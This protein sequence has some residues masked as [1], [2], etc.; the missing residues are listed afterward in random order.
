M[1]SDSSTVGIVVGQTVY[2]RNG[3]EVGTI[4]ATKT[5][6]GGR[7]RAV[8]G[9]RRFLGLSTKNV[10]IP[11]SKL[12]AREAGGFAATLTVAEIRKLPET[13]ISPR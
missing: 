1:S 7:Q 8:I 3:A 4:E 9:L 5:D 13:A 2:D 6:S 10:Q 11:A 12:S